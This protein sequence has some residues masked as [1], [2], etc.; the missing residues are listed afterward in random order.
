MNLNY[1]YINEL[2]DRAEEL[3]EVEEAIEQL[4]KETEGQKLREFELRDKFEELYLKKISIQYRVARIFHPWSEMG[5]QALK[6]ASDCEKEYEQL[7]GVLT[8]RITDSAIRK[9]MPL[10]SQ[11]IAEDIMV[12]KV[13]AIGAVRFNEKSVYAVGALAY[14]IGLDRLSEDQVLNIEWLYVASDYRH[15]G[16]A[17]I[18]LGNIL[19]R[20]MEQDIKYITFD[21]PEEDEYSQAFYNMFSD[22][23]FEFESGLSPEFVVKVSKDEEKRAVANLA[24]G[25]HSIEGM[26]REDLERIVKKLTETDGELKEILCGKRP[27]SYYDQKLSCYTMDK[28]NGALLL[29]HRMPSGL[30]KTEYLGWT[31]GGAPSIKGLISHLAVS[32]RKAY[33]DDTLIMVPVESIEQGEALDKFFPNQLRRALIEA[34]LSDPMP[35]EDI[36]CETGILIATATLERL[37]PSDIDEV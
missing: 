25:V 27:F 26:E 29:V 24:E 16:V 7:V 13:H 14:S 3:D 5:K 35:T 12:G 9:Y 28:G 11:D 21:F 8:S 30:V 6:A 22:W 17:T 32:A 15:Q 19:E 23:H 1:I 10:F 31:K 20:C 37:E 18:L 34:R 4:K 36:D 33:G 2:A